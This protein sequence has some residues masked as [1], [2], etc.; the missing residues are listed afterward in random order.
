MVPCTG[1]TCVFHWHMIRHCMLFLLGS[2]AAT[3]LHGREGAG[4]HGAEMDHGLHGASE[5]SVGCKGREGLRSGDA[6]KRPRRSAYL[7]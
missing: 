5:Q 4:A 2:L 3:Q 1:D 7:D 6:T